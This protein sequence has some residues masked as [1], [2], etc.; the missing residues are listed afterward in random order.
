MRDMQKTDDLE[1]PLSDFDP[2]TR[3]AALCALAPSYPVPTGRATNVNMHFHSFFSYNAEGYSPSRIAWEARRSGLYAAG[4]CDFDVLDGLEE[5]LDA[6]RLLGLRAAVNLE[7][8]AYLKDYAQVDISSPGEP[9][10]TYVM[11]AGFARALPADS[12]GA[13]GL[14]GYRDR[15][16]AR[17]VALVARINPHLPQIAIDYEQDVAPLTPSGAA[18]ERHIVTAYINKSRAAFGDPDALAEFWATTLAQ[19]RAETA[20]L[21]ADTPRL[22]EVVRARLA[23]RGGL[24]YEPPSV[25]TFP[26]VE[27]FMSWVAS[28][29]AIPMITWLDGT[30]VGEADGR[31][32]LECM[33]A[34]GGAALNI[35]PDRNWNVA[36]PGV[37]AAKRANLAAIVRDADGLGLPINIGTEMNKLGLPFV[38][39]L[40][41]EPLRPY[42]ESFLRGARIIVGHTLLLRYAGLSYV[43]ERAAAEFGDIAGKN[44][45]FEKVGGMPP[46]DGDRAARLE[47]MGED[48]ALAWFH[49]EAGRSGS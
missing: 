39:D 26:P 15:A 32:L 24:G 3:R 7:T 48:K 19:D 9:G 40:D 16:R 30:S 34:K 46:L 11:G 1:G 8:R 49:D 41:G 47:D 13:C 36:D 31:A 25:E 44:A 43:G 37:Q 12:A 6:G 2:G 4:L 18:T 14:A 10:V 28:C 17:N 27:E 20:S 45:F 5:F 23:K 42:K 22:E 33:T 21:L 35:I 29:G 38:D